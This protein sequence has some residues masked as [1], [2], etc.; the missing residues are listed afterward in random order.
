MPKLHSSP[1]L[2]FEKQGGRSEMV[3]PCLIASQEPNFYPD[4]IFE[5]MQQWHKCIIVLRDYV[6]TQ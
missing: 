3:H 2:T 4:K 5:V 6:D 1:C